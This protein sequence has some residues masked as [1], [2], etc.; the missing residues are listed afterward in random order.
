MILLRFYRFGN[1]WSLNVSRRF[2]LSNHA[3]P[4]ERRYYIRIGRRPGWVRTFGPRRVS[5]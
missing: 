4:G 3:Y 5:S 1:G 2:Y